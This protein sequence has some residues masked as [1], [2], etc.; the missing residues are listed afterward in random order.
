MKFVNVVKDVRREGIKLDIKFG[1]VRMFSTTRGIFKRGG[2]MTEGEGWL[3]V[4]VERRTW[5]LGG[6]MLY[7]PWLPPLILGNV[8]RLGS[9][10]HVAMKICLFY[11]GHEL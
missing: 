11:E 3:Y 1:R 2:R 7:F 8:G 10:I 6:I 4:E 9:R 5:D